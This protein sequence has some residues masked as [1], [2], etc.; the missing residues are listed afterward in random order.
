MPATLTKPPRRSPS[1]PH[2]RSLANLKAVALD[3]DGTIAER[4]RMSASTEAALQSLRSAGFRLILVSGRRLENIQQ[5]C[6][7]LD[8]FDA[9]ILENGATAFCPATGT[10]QLIA[11]P[12]DQRFV[13]DLER[14]LPG[15]PLFVGRAMVATATENAGCVEVV[16]ALGGYDLHIVGCGRRVLVLPKG[17]NKSSGLS[18]ALASLGLR[19]N[20]VVAVGDEENDIELFR[21]CAL[22]AAVGNATPTLKSAA[23]LIL[24]GEHGQS[25]Q[26][27]A[28]MLLAGVA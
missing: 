21:G 14:E 28:D 12:V 25:V 1:I 20:Q 18:H 6:G 11:P 5:I 26:Y 23:D 27:L 22:T 7:A 24:P 19:R 4:G 3:Y 15:E 17:V 16:I 2:Q 8:L 13:A 9:V 10:E